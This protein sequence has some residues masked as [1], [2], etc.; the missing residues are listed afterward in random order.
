MPYDTRADT[1]VRQNDTNAW[2]PAP[3]TH[4]PATP[5]NRGLCRLCSLP[6]GPDSLHWKAGTGLSLIPGKSLENRVSRSVEDLLRERV[7]VIRTFYRIFGN[8]KV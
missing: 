1:E 2:N 5:F 7:N 8:S 3:L 6:C 4:P